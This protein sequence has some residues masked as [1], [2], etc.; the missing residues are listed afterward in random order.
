MSILVG[1]HAEGYDYLIL[2]A[3][4]AKLL[5]V[6][7]DFITSDV[8]GTDGQGWQQVLELLPKAL[9][10]FYG[11][12]AAAAVIGID[13]DGNLDLN[14]TQANEDPKHPRHWNHAPDGE[15]ACRWCEIQRRV[16]QR[17]P[18]LNWH[19][20]KSSATWPVL[21]AVPVE[22][23]EAWILATQALVEPPAGRLVAERGPR[24]TYKRELYGGPA[25]TKEHVEGI[26]L[27][28]I[29]RLTAQNLQTLQQHSHSFDL[30]ASQVHHHRDMILNPP[31]C[32]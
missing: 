29:R 24:S 28:F 19:P 9:G 6:E 11:K 3:F 7:E 27:P 2:R 8:I 20:N 18:S 31:A 26:A 4:I 14:Q 17:L 16:S 30:F 22:A 15:P 23:V 25:A 1:F 21:I 32:P 13:N 12:C 5:P 10:R